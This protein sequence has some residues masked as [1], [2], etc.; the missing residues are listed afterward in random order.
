MTTDASEQSTGSKGPL[1]GVR[2]LD[3][4]AVVSGPM[5]AVMLADQGAEVIK[6]EP[7][8][9]GDGVRGLGA[10]RNGVSAIFTLINRNKKSV[11]INLKHPQGCALVADLISSVDVVMQNFRP[12]KMEKL[13][14]D[15]HS[16]KS[17]HPDLIYLSISGMGE[18]GPYRGQKVYDYVIQAMSGLLE[19]QAVENRYA[20]VRTII[21]DKVTAL[22][23]A[24]A[25]T[26]ALF[27]RERGAG[28]QHISL[29]MLD[30]ALYFNWPDLMWN[31]SFEGPGA[32]KAGD[33][34]DMYEIAATE[35][36]A[37]VAHHLGTD[38]RHYSTE[39]ILELF[40]QHEIP[41]GRVNS[42]DAVLTDPQI[43][44]SGT[45]ERFRHPRAGDMIHPR[46]PARFS[47]T[48]VGSQRPSPDLG[49]HT[50]DVLME[51]GYS[52]E[53]LQ[54]WAREGIIG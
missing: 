30:T 3:L 28:G 41:V 13:G 16:L 32:A 19:A 36:G 9:W 47:K 23:A 31:Q 35:D 15:Y 8:G 21:F 34:A 51:L 7:P 45:L 38:L 27:A 24:Q 10:S 26:A 1:A 42:R 49:E 54:D 6:I 2:V 44:E 33:L 29:S 40:A 48:E 18:V 37:V 25:I 20:M 43:T 52:I 39:A 46:S 50:A 22:T 5:A 14:L 53:T 4:S 12:G 17:S 11:A